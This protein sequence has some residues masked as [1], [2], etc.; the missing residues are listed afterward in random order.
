MT[1]GIEEEESA[2]DLLSLEHGK[3]YFKNTRRFENEYIT[4]NP[5]L[6]D[7]SGIIMDGENFVSC[8]KGY[9]TKCSYT[10]ESFP[11]KS[12]KL[13]PKYD[14]QNTGYIDLTGADEWTTAYCLV[15]SPSHIIDDEKRRMA[16]RINCLDTEHSEQYKYEAKIIEKNHIYDLE[17][18][19]KEN[20][21]YDLIW[22]LNDW[23]FDIPRNE[24]LVKF[25]T[26][27]SEE[28]I[29]A[30]YKRVEECRNWLKTL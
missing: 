30:I 18:F 15:N 2:I 8:K 14:W 6:I 20:P 25:T 11:F 3:A 16:W 4:G 7:K 9:D 23:T 21:G 22:D 19:L 13:D 1:K 29:K 17:L 28:K 26:Y 27:R 10:W 24:R 12:N 5:D